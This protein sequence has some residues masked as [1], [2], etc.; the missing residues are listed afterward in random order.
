M[1]QSNGNA[2][3]RSKRAASNDYR[4]Y[5]VPNH[6]NCFNEYPNTKLVL[7][8]WHWFQLDFQTKWKIYRSKSL[9]WK[10]NSIIEY[11]ICTINFNFSLKSFTA[12][13]IWRQQF[14]RVRINRLNTDLWVMIFLQMF[15]SICWTNFQHFWTKNGKLSNNFRSN[16]FEV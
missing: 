12:I 16:D 9:V 8:K 7:E 1:L 5:E 4:Y 6:W 10:K 2:V 15:H 11:T 14:L 3:D 13:S